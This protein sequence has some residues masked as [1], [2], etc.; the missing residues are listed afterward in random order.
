MPESRRPSALWFG[1][2]RAGCFG[3]LHEPA[4]ASNRGV[5]FCNALAFEGSLAHRAFRHMA[6]DVCDRG[7]WALRFDYDGEG[8]SA[9][10]PWAPHRVDAWLASID[11]AVGVLRARGVTDVRLVGFRTGATLAG[12]YATTRPGVTGVVMWAPCVRGAG[13]VREQRALSRLSAAA[14]PAQRLPSDRF[15]DDSLEVVGYELAGETLRDLE[16]LDLLA[17]GPIA[18]PELLV[19]DRDDAPPND[20][21]V[22]AFE[23]AGTEVDRHT[24]AGYEDFVTDGEEKSVLPWP[25]LHRI[26]DW[27]DASLG[28]GAVVF[29]GDGKPP[30]E[31]TSL[32]L[33]DPTAGRYLP[34]G[35]ARD[36]VLE[37]PVW[38]DD[39][40]FAIRSTPAGRSPRRPACIVLCNTGSVSRI[41]PGRLYVTLARYWASLGFTV[42]RV[43]LGGVGDSLGVNAASENQPL[44]PARIEELR[45]VLA[46][47]KR[48]TGAEHVAT[49][50]LCSGA[51]NA[52]HVA[53]E[54]LDVDHL[55]LVNPGTFYLGADQSIWSSDEAVL[56]SVHKLTRG[57]VNGRKWKLAL[58][59]REVR[60]Q[61]WRSVKFWFQASPVSRSRVVIAAAARNAARRLGFPVKSPSVLTRDLEQI[62]GRGVRVQMVFAAGESAG[63]YLRTAAGDACESL[64]GAGLDVVDIDGGDHIFSPPAARQRLIEVMTEYLDREYAVPADVPA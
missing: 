3:M 46:W 28:K 5:V 59:D 15:P 35:P 17:R 12:V 50:G 20:E 32:S 23:D 22:D 48:E 47:A 25:V 13:Y 10:G 39:R 19:I 18:P 44:A 14:R 6:D 29:D 1:R 21:L 58:R 42:L 64:A 4:V 57:F 33:D 8:D 11:A 56:A 61:G 34:D 55:L 24:M 26:E 16:R 62:V 37:T 53:L 2:E 31:R 41:G 49:G 60:R 36:C 7:F 63:R 9:G 43:D 30:I 54:G 27:L 45:D 40:F 52:F 51:F 38:V